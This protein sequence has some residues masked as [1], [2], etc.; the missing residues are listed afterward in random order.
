MTDAMLTREKIYPPITSVPFVAQRHRDITGSK[1]LSTLQIA[2][3]WICVWAER[4]RQR[5]ALRELDDRLLD[6]I[7]LT[8]EQAQNEASKFFW[9]D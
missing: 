7:G 3:A 8:R 6:D 2:M 4:S 9:Q 1:D 5:R